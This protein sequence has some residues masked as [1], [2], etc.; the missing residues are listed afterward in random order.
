[1]VLKKYNILQS[2]PPGTCVWASEKGPLG[3]LRNFQDHKESLEGR[4]H[5]PTSPLA[6]PLWSFPFSI[7]KETMHQAQCLSP[8][9]PEIHAETS[10]LGKMRN[11]GPWNLVGHNLP[12][13]Q[14]GCLYSTMPFGCPVGKSQER[15]G[16]GHPSGGQGARVTDSSCLLR[17]GDFQ[18]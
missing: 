9:W 17:T 14:H 18:Y 11:N 15:R 3:A 10:L 5:D 7:R 4:E 8:A 12:W 1:M 16:M 2:I 6:R 13:G